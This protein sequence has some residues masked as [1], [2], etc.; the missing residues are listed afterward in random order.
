MHLTQLAFA[1]DTS[2]ICLGT[3]REVSLCEE[4]EGQSTKVNVRSERT[5]HAWLG[6]DKG[7]RILADY[8]ASV[9]TLRQGNRGLK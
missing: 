6:T 7:D 1:D 3:P 5:G 8:L 4:G 9:Y 2:L